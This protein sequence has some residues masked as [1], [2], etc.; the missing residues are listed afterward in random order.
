MNGLFTTLLILTAG[1]SLIILVIY[2]FSLHALNK[3]AKNL[4]SGDLQTSIP[5]TPLP[6]LGEIS[7]HYNFLSGA[8]TDLQRVEEYQQR[9]LAYEKNEMSHLLEKEVLSRQLSQQLSETRGANQ[10]ISELNRDLEKKNLSLNEAINRLSSLNQLSRMLGMEHDR[11]K[12]YRM[13]V[14][15]SRELLQA[16]IG[17]LLL[18]DEDGK[19]LHLEYSQGFGELTDSRRKMAVGTGMAGWVASH[20]KPLLVR[21]FKNQEIFSAKSSMGYERKTA[22]SAPIAIGEEVIGVISLINKTNGK[23]FNEDERTLLAT[24]ASET[25]MALHNALLLEKVQT[26]YFNMVQSLITAVEAKDI[27]TRGHSER[28]TQYS[29]LIAE[30]MCLSPERMEIIQKAGVLHDIGKITIELAILNKPS[31]LDKDEY[32]KIKVHPSVGYRILEP[33][34]FEYDIKLCVL[35]HH[36]RPDGKGY[37]NGTNAEEILLEARIMA[38]ADAFDA[39]TTK[40]P[41]RDPM[42]VQVALEELERYAGSQFDPDAVVAL[43]KIIDMLVSTDSVSLL[44]S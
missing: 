8:V 21:N 20:K 15:L 4:E 30:Q 13:I 19:S 31:T 25:S 17:H 39:M 37:P 28:V 6:F 42:S 18:M 10:T 1:I 5:N 26:G 27:Y 7:R 44:H 41:Y 11:K 43:K 23:S 38:V 35:Q 36:E 34:D 2:A 24:I 40:R 29:Q 33:I 22:I 9:M 14:S 12:I 32:E 3:A 16:E